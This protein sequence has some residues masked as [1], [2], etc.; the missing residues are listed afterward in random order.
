MAVPFV[1]WE[2]GKVREEKPFK[3]YRVRHLTA[4][5]FVFK[6]IETCNS[7]GI[8]EAELRKD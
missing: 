1:E 8:F 4:K 7:R 5:G 2:R 6:S 3:S